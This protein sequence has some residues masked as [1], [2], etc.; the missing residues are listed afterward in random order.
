MNDLPPRHD[1]IRGHFAFEL[2][3][4]MKQNPNIWVVTG[5]L[6]YKM[7]D[8]IRRDFESRFINTGAT[9]AAMLGTAVGLAKEGKIPFCYSIS[10][11]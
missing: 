11:F 1:S 6:G 5:D 7:F 10:T 2:Y 3:K 9:E 4:E 8:F